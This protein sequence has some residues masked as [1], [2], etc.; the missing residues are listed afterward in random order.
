MFIVEEADYLTRGFLA[1]G[2]RDRER[3]RRR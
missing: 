1:A 3:G 2:S